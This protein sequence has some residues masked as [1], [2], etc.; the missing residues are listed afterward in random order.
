MKLF[1]EN[2]DKSNNQIKQLKQPEFLKCQECKKEIL[3]ELVHSN[4]SSCVYCGYLF[5]VPARGR[6]EMIADD[7]SF[8][9]IS[10]SKTSSNPLNFPEYDQKLKQAKRSSGIN[11][12]IVCGTCR[13]GGYKCGLG[14][15]DSYFMM[16]SM[17]QIVGGKIT[18]LAEVC[19]KGNLPL[20]IFCASGGARMQEGVLSLLQMSRTTAAMNKLHDAGLLYVTVLTNPTTGGVTA[21]FA[22]QADIILAEPKA[23]IGFAGPRVIQQ[24]VKDDLPEEF[25]TSEYLLENGMIDRI[26]ERKDMRNT[27]AQILSLHSH[28]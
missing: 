18:D 26:V 11:E 7:D 1:N 14:V 9:E 16:G 17:G 4:L 8:K 25:Q 22:M 21:S 6:I 23:L 2:I 3:K 10:K 20:I 24:T 13:I 28:V 12:A 19:L 15:M 27:L 5:R